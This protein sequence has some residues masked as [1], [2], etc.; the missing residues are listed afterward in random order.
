VGREASAVRA[1]F[2]EFEQYINTIATSFAFY[3]Y[4]PDDIIAGDA[5]RDFAWFVE[6]YLRI[7]RTKYATEYDHIANDTCW[8]QALLS[9]WGRVVR[10]WDETNKANVNKLWDEEAA[11]VD[12]L[13]KNPVLLAEIENL[14]VIDGCRK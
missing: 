2:S 8:R 7:V 11:K 4:A 6:R 9:Q 12:V 1:V 3:D 13:L 14:R 10:Y 5:T